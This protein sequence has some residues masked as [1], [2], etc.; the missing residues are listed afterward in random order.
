MSEREDLRGT[1]RSFDPVDGLGTIEL[2]GGRAVRF[3]LSSWEGAPHVRP[4]PGM[5]VA[6]FGLIP[7]LSDQLK[8]RRVVPAVAVIRAQGGTLA[9]ELVTELA[10]CGLNPTFDHDALAAE[11]VAGAAKV[12]LEQPARLS[13]ARALV[14]ELGPPFQTR[15]KHPQHLEGWL[16]LIAEATR[17]RLPGLTLTR[18]GSSVVGRIDGVSFL[19]IPAAGASSLRKI[20][21][22]LNS[23]LRQERDPRRWWVS[24]EDGDGEH[25]G[26][27]QT[28]VLAPEPLRDI[29]GRHGLWPAFWVASDESWRMHLPRKSCY[30]LEAASCK[31]DNT[32]IRIVSGGLASV[33]EELE[34]EKA[35]TDLLVHSDPLELVT[36]QRGQVAARLD[37]RAFV[38]VSLRGRPPQPLLSPAIERA[39]SKAVD[40][41]RE[42]RFTAALDW[43]AATAAT[44][45]LEPPVLAPDELTVLGGPDSD[46]ELLHGCWDSVTGWHPPRGLRATSRKRR[47]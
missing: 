8:A 18:A 33:R 20:A 36:V 21:E 37:L 32:R 1:V 5:P 3:G 44:P 26:S 43:D 11:L 2:E 35:L 45:A 14:A 31:Q 16:P 9:R 12:V 4:E 40:S 25:Q 46:D 6:I 28:W 7:W 30:L 13:L 19:E 10:S 15:R 39:F 24:H 22:R 27:Y 17:R 34:R 41:D 23:R 42:L 38:R 47:A 29:L